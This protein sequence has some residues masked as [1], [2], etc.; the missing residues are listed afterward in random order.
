MRVVPSPSPPAPAQPVRGLPG[1]ARRPAFTVGLLAIAIVVSVVQGQPPAANRAS[2]VSVPV[3]NDSPFPPPVGTVVVVTENGRA[4]R[5]DTVTRRQV[6]LALPLAVTALR[7]WTAYGIDVVYGRLRDGRTVAYAVR[8]GQLAT[9]LGPAEDVVP[10]ADG[11][12]VW[13]VRGG[14]ATRLALHP[15]QHVLRV[16]LPR[17]ANLVA[18]TPF[19]LVAT[20]GRV[21]QSAPS[22]GPAPTTTPP[23]VTPPA[24][25]PPAVTS[26]ARGAPA[27]GTSPGSA[28]PP[29]VRASAGT[30]GHRPTG[31][32]AGT[33]APEPLA[34]LLVR[35]NG[36]TRVI[37]E[38]EAL[39]ATGDVVLVRRA[40]RRLGVVSSRGGRPRWLPKLSAVEVTGPA[41]LSRDGGETFAALARVNDHVRMMVGPTRAEGEGDLNVVALE[42]GPPRPDAA[43]PVFGAAGGI[44][45]VRPDGRVVYYRARARQGLLLGEDVPRARS[46]GPG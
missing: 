33:P 41:A 15:G 10:S 24:V 17:A 46:V 18:D 45:A 42:G 8:P 3:R 23:A 25:T 28:R 39:A 29:T 40:D 13:L 27:A 5:F 9:P 2:G 4:T 1:W 43:P 20:T 35:A 22:P 26:G 19:G 11:R 7:A 32:P 21:P 38:A 6:P 34:A 36:L 44:F 16:R 12:T 30:R 14:T 31:T 37:A